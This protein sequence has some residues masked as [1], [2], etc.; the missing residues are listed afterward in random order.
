MRTTLIDVYEFL[1]YQQELLAQ[2]AVRVQAATT[3]MMNFEELAALYP[4]EVGKIETTSPI[5]QKA[6]V[7]LAAIEEKLRALRE[8]SDGGSV[9]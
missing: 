3:V 9:Q 8:N 1:K 2:I 4:V 5:A 6:V 7:I